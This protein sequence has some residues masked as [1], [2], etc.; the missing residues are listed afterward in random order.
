MI[1]HAL[2]F[3]I[4]AFIALLPASALFAQDAPLSKIEPLTIASEGDAVMFTVE[5]ADTDQL[6]ERGLMFRQRLPQDRGMLFD[7]GEPPVRGCAI[8]APPSLAPG[9]HNRI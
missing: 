4:F 6:R 9:R 7:F 2:T 8:A 5:I 3:F 1:R